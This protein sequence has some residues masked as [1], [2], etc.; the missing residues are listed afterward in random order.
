[1]F[2]QK[3]SQNYSGHQLFA[4]CSQAPV[5][6]PSAFRQ[7]VNLS[8]RGVGV[9]HEVSAQHSTGLFVCRKTPVQGKKLEKMEIEPVGCSG[10]GLRSGGSIRWARDRVWRRPSRC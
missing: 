9:C 4:D 7:N 2:V 5:T 1:M 10:A 3:R 8:W 6:T